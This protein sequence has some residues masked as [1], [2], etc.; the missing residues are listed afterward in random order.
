MKSLSSELSWVNRHGPV[1]ELC[2]QVNH[3]VVVD[4]APMETVD[5]K[6][7]SSYYVDLFHCPV[8]PKR[9]LTLSLSGHA[10]PAAADDDALKQLPG[11]NL[12]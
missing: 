10:D 6:D 2:V 9:D 3:P 7:R 5:N 11:L 12:E 8:Y 4:R 1:E